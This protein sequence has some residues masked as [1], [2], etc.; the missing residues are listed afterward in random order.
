MA[1][2][3]DSESGS[4][5]PARRGGAPQ[6]GVQNGSEGRQKVISSRNERIVF[7]KV[8]FLQGVLCADDLIFL[9]GMERA[10]AQITS[11]VLTRKFQIKWFKIPLQRLKLQLSLGLLS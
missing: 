2:L 9:Q 5:H 3:R 11:Q 7:G 8:N 4:I 1:L 6:G 10:Q